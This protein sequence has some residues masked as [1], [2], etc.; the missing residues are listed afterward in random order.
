MKKLIFGIVL[1]CAFEIV[2]A[3]NLQ[4]SGGNN[5]S[6]AVCDNQTVFTWGANTSGQLALDSFDV[7]VSATYRNTI[8]AV[9]RGNVSNVAATITY[10]PLPAI[11]QVDAGSGAHLLG[12]SC[13]GQ[14][15]AWGGGSSGQLGRGASAS[16][17][18]PQR[19]LR[20]VQ[21]AFVNPDDPNGIFLNNIFYVSGGNNSSFALE[22]GTG[23]VLAWG[24][25]TNGQLGDGSILNRTT[26]VYVTKS[27]AEGGGQLTN[28][29]QIEGGDDCTYALDANGN[30]W[31]WGDNNGNKLGR[32]GA[33]IQSTAG[34]VVQGDPLNN[35]YSTTPTPTVFLNGIIQISGGDTHCLALDANGNVWSFGG[36]W[37][38]GQLGRSGGSVYQDDARKVSIPGLATYATAN[39][40]FLGNGV[41]G[42][43]VYVSAG[44]A[45]SAVVMA[46]G[47][48]VTFGA[49][50]L[51]N[52]GATATAAGGSIACPS[53]T[54]D[55][56]PSG[57]IGDGSAACNSTMCNGKA[58]QFTRTPVYVTT[59]TTG[60]H[61]TGIISVSDGDAWFYAVAASGAAYT[62]GWNR[63][64]ELG[65]GDYADRCFATPFIL[66][67]GCNF[68]NP[69]P[70]KPNLGADV[71]TCPV[72]STTLNSNVPQTYSSYKYTW[73]YRSGTSGTWSPLG[74]P[75]GNDVTYTPANLL[76]QY[77]VTISDNRA[78]VPLLCG[79]CPVYMDTITFSQI[80]NP[81]TATG[82]SNGVTGTA[83]FSVTAPPGVKIKWYTNPT[84]GIA[85]NPSDSNATITVPFSS[86]NTSTPGC[87]MALYADDVTS[88]AGVLR[89]GTTVASAPCAAAGVTEN[90]NR[91]PLMIEVS[92]NILLTSVSFIQPNNTNPYSATY[93]VRI[94]SNDPTNGYNCGGCTP[95][96]S[97]LGQPGT[98]LY[99]SPGT[100]LGGAANAGD[101]V[102]TLTTSYTLTGTP[103]APV[104]YWIYVGGGDV[105]Y[106]NCNPAVTQTGV[107]IPIWTTPQNST[108]AA[109]RA[110]IALHDNNPQGNSNVFNLTFNVGTSYAC[111]RI[112]VC[113]DPTCS[114]LPVELLFFNAVKSGS[115]V[116][117]HW[118]TGSEL[119]SDHFI[120]QRSVDAI[121]WDNIGTVDAKGNSSSVAE[122]S[123][124]DGEIVGE[125][126]Y[127]RIIVKD[128]DGTDYLSSI[129]KIESGDRL[130]LTA[131]PNPSNGHFFINVKGAHEHLI[132]ILTNS[133]G[134]KIFEIDEE[135]QGSYRKEMN[136][137]SLARG[138]YYL[139]VK[140]SGEQQYIKLI[141]D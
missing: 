12:L 39:N 100:V 124:T 53:P 113:V 87:A 93:S 114:V 131:E 136:F 135:V 46:N 38:E 74:T 32:P 137:T 56:I 133:M 7:P 63:R 5:F 105:K 78:S 115:S 44:Q 128:A 80:P 52:A 86:T 17:P 6:A 31:S 40:Q 69:C 110:L 64:G 94:Y 76:G 104:K 92:Q 73:E 95:A 29:I 107:P 79:P 121:N 118:A 27:L 141:L 48:V 99:T 122:Y 134:Q 120:V 11:R 129:E 119:N 130:Q 106:F 140:N 20:G 22:T 81:Y 139:S 98:L 67:S 96:N 23:R 85:L 102:R 9:I 21:T 117:L 84:G 28:I 16:S 62:W 45:N 41:D 125:I 2:K 54:G 101:I 10:G 51:Y 90:G 55:M 108:P 33:G 8:E 116:E 43:A 65:L 36:D 18:I 123:F 1:I 82:C 19:V 60:T 75:M 72:F 57:S 70:G 111:D 132:M 34:R 59:N 138:V 35:G 127:Y 83:N 126:V 24:E 68:S 112:L 89:P 50:G 91:S 71:I 58:T 77:R 14:V 42:K 88:F 3:Q 25:N 26:P 30:V 47:K 37:G 15:W 49:R 61:L 13:K 103:A 66:P 97:K 109:M 4:I